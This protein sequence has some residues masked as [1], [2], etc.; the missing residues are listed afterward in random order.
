MSQRLFPFGIVTYFLP[1]AGTHS[2]IVI[3][4]RHVLRRHFG[5][6]FRELR[7]SHRATD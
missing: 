1:I 4:A 6:D 7:E 3:R 5:A 2:L